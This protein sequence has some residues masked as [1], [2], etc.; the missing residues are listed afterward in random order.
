[1]QRNLNIDLENVLFNENSLQK[2][3]I[4]MEDTSAENV[5]CE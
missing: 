5:A 4:N 3:P 1:M 2:D